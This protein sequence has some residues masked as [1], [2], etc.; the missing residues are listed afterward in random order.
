[1]LYDCSQQEVK[2]LQQL[3][4]AKHI[5]SPYFQALAKNRQIYSAIPAALISPHLDLINEDGIAAAALWGARVSCL[6]S[7]APIFMPRYT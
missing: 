6:W 1:M 2:F 3:L 5:T 7:I 4:W